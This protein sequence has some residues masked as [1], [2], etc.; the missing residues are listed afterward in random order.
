MIFNLKSIQISDYDYDLPGNRIAQYPAGERDKSKLLVMKAGALSKDTFSNIADHI[1]SDSLL[2]FNNSRVIRARL[3]FGKESGARIEVLCLEP[4]SPS[5]Y[6]SSFSSKDPVEWKCII[7]NLKKWKKGKIRLHF[8]YKDK[9][10]VLEAEK[11]SPEGEAWRVRFEWEAREARFDEVLEAAGHIPL[12]PYINRKDEN[13]DSVSYQT[14]YSSIM[15]SVAAPTAGLHFTDDVFSKLA[16]KGIKKAEITL[17]VGAGTFQPVKTEN[18]LDHE[19]HAEH[20]FIRRET[21]EELKKFQG[22]IIPVGTTSVRTIESIY[23]LGSK[24]AAKKHF[25]NGEFHIGQWEAYTTDPE[26]SEN[27]ALNAIST[28]MD[29]NKLLS[30]H[31]STSLMIVPGYKFH[32]TKGIITNFHQPRSTLLMLICA[33]AGE[34]WKEIYRFAIEND[35]RFLSY[36]DSSLLLPY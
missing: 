26:V 15:G 1:P 30:L 18:A 4:L 32:L 9:P 21:I 20:F 28:Y 33:W 24:I 14:V 17:H 34:R 3:L 13:A 16:K 7:G 19:M 8:N 2:V 11:I 25:K 36:G 5:V 29:A 31:V 12:P 27:E 10:Q 23:L 35:F 22:R 6:E